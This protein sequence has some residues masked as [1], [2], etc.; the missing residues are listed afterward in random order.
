MYTFL[1]KYN[2]VLSCYGVSRDN[3][4]NEQLFRCDTSIDDFNIRF[5]YGDT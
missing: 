4:I 5:D 3:P 1:E 2:K